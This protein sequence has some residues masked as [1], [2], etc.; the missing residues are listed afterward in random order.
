MAGLLGAGPVG[1]V[2]LSAYYNNNPPFSNSMGLVPKSPVG[3]F[4]P[5]VAQ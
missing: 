2:S 4:Q 3:I 1:A 5:G